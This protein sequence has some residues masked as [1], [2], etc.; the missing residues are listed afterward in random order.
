MQ[1]L[2]VALVI[3]T[4]PSLQS[5]L[6]NLLKVYEY[7]IDKYKIEVTIFTDKKNNFSYPKFKIEKVRGIDYKTPLEKIFLVLGLQRFYY[8]D[9]IE[10]L[11]GFDVIEASNPEFYWF[12][13][14][15][16]LAAKNCNFDF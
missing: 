13:Y 1:K 4:Q 7:L 12:A 6:Q 14:Q 9:L 3:P 16:Y 2:R 11:K 8:T 10:K 15:S 5:S